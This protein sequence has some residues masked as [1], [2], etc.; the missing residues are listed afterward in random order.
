MGSGLSHPML[1]I[2]EYN[3]TKVPPEQ[4]TYYK[5]KYHYRGVA[6]ERE[7][8]KTILEDEIRIK[9]GRN[10]TSVKLQLKPNMNSDTVFREFICSKRPTDNSLRYEIESFLDWMKTSTID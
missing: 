9:V 10:N 1:V 2:T 4:V 3:D 6:F 8:F 5:R 7:I